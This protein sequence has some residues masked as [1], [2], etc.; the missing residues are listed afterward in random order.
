MQRSSQSAKTSHKHHFVQVP[1]SIQLAKLAEI[2]R[3]LGQHDQDRVLF[4]LNMFSFAESSA[5]RI[6]SCTIA[7][8]FRYAR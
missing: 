6:T 8:L 5:S 3:L 2:F 7:L 4:A 1:P